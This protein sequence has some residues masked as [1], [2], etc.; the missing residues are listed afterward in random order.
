MPCACQ[1]HPL[2]KRAGPNAVGRSSRGIATQPNPHTSG[3][4]KLVDKLPWKPIG[5][6]PSDWQ[7]TRP[8][9]AI[10]RV[11]RWSTR[12]PSEKY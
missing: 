3:L 11:G 4:G 8:Q 12:A 1:L 6:L 9:G 2:P 7:C 10:V 5:V